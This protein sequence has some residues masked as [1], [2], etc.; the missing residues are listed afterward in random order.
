MK[1]WERQTAA[2]R[3]KQVS[4][5]SAAQQSSDARA[6]ENQHNPGWFARPEKF[7]HGRPN[8]ASQSRSQRGMSSNARSNNDAEGQQRGEEEEFTGGLQIFDDQDYKRGMTVSDTD[9]CEQVLRPHSPL[10]IPEQA[11]LD[12]RDDDLIPFPRTQSFKYQKNQHGHSSNE[13]PLAF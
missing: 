9:S 2:S 1:I 12:G 8:A 4:R 11:K 10:Q 5:N 13:E 6:L 3:G 7:T